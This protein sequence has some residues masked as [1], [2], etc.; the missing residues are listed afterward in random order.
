MDSEKGLITSITKDKFESTLPDYATYMELENII[1]KEFP[2]ASS[3]ARARFSN[4]LIGDFS[5]NDAKYVV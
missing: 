2:E 5:P 3:A 1:Q 4:T